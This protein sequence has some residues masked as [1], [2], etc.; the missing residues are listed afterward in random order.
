MFRVDRSK[1]SLVR[2][3]QRRFDD[4]D[5]RERDHLQEWLAQMP[6]A[7]GEELLIVQ[8]EFDGFADTRERLDLLALDKEGRLV[9]VENKLDDSGRDV[10]WQGLKY[11][12][13]C[14]SLRK[15][16]IVEIYQEYLDRWSEGADAVANLCDFLGVAELDDMVLNAGNDQRLVLVAANFRKE[17]TAAVLWLLGHGVRAQCFRVVPY[18]FENELFI[19]LQQIIPTPEAADYMIRIADKDTAEKSDQGAS[20]RRHRLRQAFWTMALEQLRARNVSRFENISPSNDHWLSCATGVSGCTYSLIFSK[21]EVR[22]ELWLQRSDAAVNKW[23][24][25]QLERE[26]QKFDERFGQELLWRRLNDKKTSIISYSHAF[27]GFNRENWPEMINWLC[28]HIVRLDQAFSEPL[29]DLNQQLKAGS[30]PAGGDP[31]TSQ[32]VSDI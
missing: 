11:V 6:E 4:L 15:A 8:K 14:S 31:S 20:Q 17:V 1:N 23:I 22:V 9:V 2:L 32:D 10:V 29:A 7:L 13:Y 24:F 3:A 28:D 18:S 21:K 16:E 5:L 30:G 12:A 19:D 27:D 25:D 26:R